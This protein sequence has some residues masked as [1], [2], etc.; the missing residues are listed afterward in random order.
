M[1]VKDVLLRDPADYP[2]VNNGQARIADDSERAM[3]ELEGEL[4]TFVCEGQYA[5]GIQRILDSFLKDRSRTSQRA[6]WVSGFFGSGKSHLL[7]VLC[8]LWRDTKFPDGATARTLVPALPDEIRAQLRE[9]DTAGRQGGGLVSAAGALPAGT[10]DQVRLT[11]L[12]VLLKGLGLPSLYPQARFCLWL[13]EQGWF[14]K[15]KQAVEAAGKT[16]DREINDLYVSGALAKAILAL[17]PG[18]ASNEAEARKRLQ[19]QFPYQA[20]DIRSDEFLRIVTDALRLAGRGGKLPCTLLVLDEVQQYIGHSIDRSVLVT[21]T[22]EAISKQLDA[23]VMVVG[24]GQSALT[25]IPLLQK[26]MDRFTVRVTLSDNDVET[27]TRKVLLQKKA[28]YIGDVRKLLD[29]NAGEVSRQLQ[30]TRIGERAE[31]QVVAVDDYPLLPVRR[32]FW[33][34]CFRQIDAAGTQSQ[35]RSQLR[36]I[37]DAVARQSP[38]DLGAVVPGDELFDALAPEMVNT[39]VL[40]R[41]LN[42]KIVGLEAT[43][44]PLARRVA[45]LVFLIGRLPRETGI[46][47]GIRAT[48]AHIADLLVDDLAGDN[49]KLRAD[50]AAILKRLAQD[51]VLLE[52][53]N[54]YRLQTR[55]GAEWDREFRTRQQK[56]STDPA[57]E[58]IKRE[59]LLYA[60]L[61]RVVGTIHLL[62]GAAKVRRTLWISHDANLPAGDG[63]GLVAWARDGWSMA[64]KDVVA[65]ARAAGFD[66][67]MLFIH[68]PRQTADD[69]KNAIVDAEAAQ[70]TLD[71]KGSPSTPEGQEARIGMQ[72]RCDRAERERDRLIA[73]IVGC[74]KVFQ[75]GGNEVLLPTLPERLGQAAEAG[76]VRLYPR[77]KDADHGAWDA[78]IKRAKEGSDAPFQPVGHSGPIERHPVAQQVL[79]AAGNGKT[80]T[81]VR[82]ELRAAPFGWPQD[83]VDAALIALHRAQLLTATLNGTSVALGQLD[84][85]R[86]PKA[87]F[88]AERATLTVVERAEL[89]K[90]FGRLD[91]SCKSGEEGQRA[92]EFLRALLGLARASGGEPPLPAAPATADIEDLAR[93]AGNEQLVALKSRADELAKQIDA[94]KSRRDLAAARLPGWR[95]L[96]GLADHAAPLPAAQEVLEQVAAINEQRLLLEPSDPVLP[97]RGSLADLLRAEVLRLHRAFVERLA[98]T[99]AG[100]QQD[101]AWARTLSADREAILASVGLSQPPEPAIGSH[102]E[103]LGRLRG[104]PLD[105]CANDI[106]ALAGRASR[107]LVEAARRLKGPVREVSQISIEPAT[108]E[109]DAELEAWLARQRE[110]IHVALADGPVVVG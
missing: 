87:I 88:R 86:I 24:A 107:A 77:F 68:I 84:Q 103:L 7:K 38:R 4:K 109:S 85:S 32:R 61:G 28:P 20:N 33:E 36:I 57:Q 5:D 59:Q 40:L 15:V 39:G 63:E 22:V 67:P 56:L 41:E 50:T 54:E 30:G 10:T 92:P 102:D 91:I 29:N 108:I 62:Q 96:V 13:R 44:G 106:D 90:L 3:Q 16:F 100:F 74:A 31:D 72:T 9:L 17:D 12:A 48:D 69:L 94:W 14:E 104:K 93:L 53:D 43:H 89:R 42:E 65:A 2:L 73:E 19:G 45:G 66:D 35:L 70:Q 11:I 47:L 105:A 81:E 21:E 25:E 101:A 52:V 6:A 60:E 78:A 34:A 49:G 99:I 46:D 76:L 110:R 27:V 55:E 26:L 97:L 82:R 1:K 23:Q 8:H 80:G 71:A 37:H 75:G 95:I 58:E 98:V 18:F 51:G 83:A 79:T 64:E